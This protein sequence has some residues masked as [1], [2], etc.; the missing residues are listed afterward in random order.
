M[1]TAPE[2]DHWLQVIGYEVWMLGETFKMVA[3]QAPLLIAS[4]LLNAISESRVLHARNLCD[5]CNPPWRQDDIKPSDLFD[6]YDTATEYSTLRVFVDGAAKAYTTDTCPVV[7]P[8][9][10]LELRSPK[11]AFDKKLAHPTRQRGTSFDYSRFVDVV[12][13]KL[14]QVVEEMGRMEKM[15]GRNFPTLG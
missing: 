7:M 15:Q 14:Q 11:W 8:D 1:A 5:F 12:M 10:R 2:R 13:P 9:G 4:S 3:V 6:N